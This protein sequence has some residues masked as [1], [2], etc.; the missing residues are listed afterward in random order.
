VKRLELDDPK[1]E[2]VIDWYQSGMHVFREDNWIGTPKSSLELHLLS[3]TRDI[4]AQSVERLRPLLDDLSV[5]GCVKDVNLEN[6]REL[7]RNNRYNARI[8]EINQSFEEEGNWEMTSYLKSIYGAIPDQ[9]VSI[10]FF[11]MDADIQNL[12]ST[13]STVQEIEEA[14]REDEDYS[15]TGV[16]LSGYSISNFPKGSY[17]MLD[18]SM[19]FDIH[20]LYGG[21]EEL[22]E[23]YNRV[24]DR[25]NDT[26]NYSG[27]P[28][29][30]KVGQRE[31]MGYFY[32]SEEL[33]ADG[34]EVDEWLNKNLGIGPS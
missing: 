27:V 29:T 24:S 17:R 5:L 9:D 19:L 1:E 8:D 2:T 16:E 14:M 3:E 22:T 4:G 15:V 31:P 26:N 13:V 23:E 21:D 32:D 28:G 30:V 20:F 11:S 7:E 34:S 10:E 12:E 6:M 18:E 33:S 25:W